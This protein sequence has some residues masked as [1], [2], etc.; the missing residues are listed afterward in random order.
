MNTGISA[1][2]DGALE[3]DE[4]QAVLDELKRSASGRETA[5]TYCL[6]GDALRGENR[7]A[8]NL[9]S[10]V[11]ARLEGEPIFIAPR[12]RMNQVRSLM[13]I[14]ASAAG[15]ALVAWLALTP[16]GEHEAPLLASRTVKA[17]APVQVAQA[18]GQDMQE[19][20]IAHQMHSGTLHFSE[21]AQQIRTVSFVEK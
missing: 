6:I 7:L 20:L 21:G 15:V 16:Q 1:L 10:G 12:R 9:A 14:A 18:S 13:A 17:P 2:L 19:Y 4:A 11:M 3:R 5:A 8:M